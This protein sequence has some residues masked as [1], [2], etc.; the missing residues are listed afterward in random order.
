MGS[1]M[2]DNS[3]A[4]HI[5]LKINIFTELH[6]QVPR[7]WIDDMKRGELRMVSRR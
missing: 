6:G 4:W 5:Y 3:M 7:R 2:K 1:V